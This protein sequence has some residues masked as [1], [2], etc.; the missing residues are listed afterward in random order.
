MTK[1]GASQL[2]PPGG[3]PILERKR[4]LEHERL[5]LCRDAVA[6]VDTAEKESWSTIINELIEGG[7]SE[8]ELEAELA[9]SRNTIYKWKTGSAAPREMTRRL[10]QRS[11]LE[12]VEERLHQHA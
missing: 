10:L 8:A 11:I 6:G 9:A 5:V 7:F 12:M 1:D 4:R 2:G 3:D